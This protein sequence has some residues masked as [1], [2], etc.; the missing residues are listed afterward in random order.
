LRKTLG[1]MLADTFVFDVYT[2]PGLKQDQKSVA[3]GLILQDA[4]RTL[5]DQ[6]ADGCVAAAL[7]SLETLFGARLRN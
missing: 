4:S 2:G 5:T 1:P 6:D 7:A 3:M